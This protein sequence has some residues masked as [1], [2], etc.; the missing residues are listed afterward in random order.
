MPRGGSLAPI[1][2]TG[3]TLADVT[4][5]ICARVLTTNGT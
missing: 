2:T 4:R 1:A 3:R 5:E